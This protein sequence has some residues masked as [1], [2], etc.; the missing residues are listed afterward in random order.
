MYR[1]LEYFQL[2]RS[3][4]FLDC[5]LILGLGQGFLVRYRGRVGDGGFW[6]GQKKGRVW[7]AHTA[8][9]FSTPNQSPQG[10]KW[11]AVPLPCF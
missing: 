11:L 2:P 4:E 9:N 6:D 1:A 10:I 7:V 3:I 5:V 8:E